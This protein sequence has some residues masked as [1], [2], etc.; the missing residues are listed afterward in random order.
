MLCLVVFLTRGWWAAGCS[1][2]TI[3]SALLAAGCSADGLA[4]APAGG[5]TMDPASVSS[6]TLGGRPGLRFATG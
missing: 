3:G 5:L 2:L 6:G 4:T 1:V